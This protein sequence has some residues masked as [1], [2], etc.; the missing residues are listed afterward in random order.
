MK[1]DLNEWCRKLHATSK[2]NLWWIDCKER[3]ILPN[4]KDKMEDLIFCGNKI[5]LKH[6]EV[7]EMHEGL[8]KG[9]PDK[10]LPLRSNEEVEAADI[11]IRLADYCG[12]RNLDLLGAVKEKMKYNSVREDHKIKNR[13]KEGGKKF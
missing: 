11:F 6:G 10:H 3:T 7:S 9:L 8:R 4:G 2:G 5:A 1:L 13:N 12:A